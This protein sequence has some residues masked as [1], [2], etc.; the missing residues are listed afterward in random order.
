MCKWNESTKF[1]FERHIVNKNEVEIPYDLKYE[2]NIDKSS[3]VDKII[4]VSNIREKK[5]KCPAGRCKRTYIDFYCNDKTFTYEYRGS[6]EELCEKAGEPFSYIDL[7]YLGDVDIARKILIGKTVYTTPKT[8]ISQNSQTGK[9]GECKQYEKVIITNVGTSLKVNSPVRIFFKDEGGLEFYI[10]VY[11]S[12]TNMSIVHY[13]N[14][15]NY[16][17]YV[18]CFSDIRL[19]YPNISDANWD[20]IKNMSVKIGMD[21]TEC[22]L[23]LGHPSKKNKDISKNG[24]ILE[25]WVYSNL[26]VYFKDDK[27]DYIQSR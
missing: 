2:R 22:T 24:I 6:I 21:K 11:L 15:F 23:S 7:V 27:I 20:C 9:I 3:L 4:Y 26:Y 16:F 17:P 10:D 18:F 8:T 25:Q 14:K 19:K 12:K 13:E 1:M 5:V